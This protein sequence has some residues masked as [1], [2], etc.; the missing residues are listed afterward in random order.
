MPLGPST[1][2]LLR[3]WEQSLSQ[4]PIRRVLTLLAAADPQTGPEGLA[5][6]CIGRRDARLLALREQLFGPQVAGLATCPACGER[7]ELSFNVDDIRVASPPPADTGLSVDVDGCRARFRLPDSLD[8]AAVAGYSDVASARRMLLERCVLG[9]EVNGEARP[10]SPIAPRLEAAI[11]EEM[12]R[13]D[14][15][16]D[17]QL[18]LTC[19]ACRHQWQAAFDIAAFFW[20]E[21]SAWAYRLLDEIH[22]LAAAYGWSETEILAL[23]PWRRQ[24]YLRRVLG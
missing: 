13:A 14:S 23:T 11:V 3:A 24:F 21:L 18:K 16:A 20:N 15:Q 8:L 7:L 6:F 9:L 17:V 10:S 22:C 4:S 12:A 1:S 5:Q 2:D 19:F